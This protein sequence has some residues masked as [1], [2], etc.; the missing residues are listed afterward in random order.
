MDRK[1]DGQKQSLPKSSI[2]TI[3]VWNPKFKRNC[4]KLVTNTKT[5]TLKLIRPDIESKGLT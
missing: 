5:C 2:F 4:N 3:M 1:T